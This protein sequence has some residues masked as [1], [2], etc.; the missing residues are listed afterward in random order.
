M[1]R[2]IIV[3][4]K[5]KVTH[6]RPNGT[7]RDAYIHSINGG[8]LSKDQLHFLRQKKSSR[9]NKFIFSKRSDNRHPTSLKSAYANHFKHYTS[10]G[11][12]RD[13]YVTC[14]EG[15]N[16]QP[17]RW[18]DQPDLKFK[19]SLRVQDNHHYVCLMRYSEGCWEKQ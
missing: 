7:G 13:H 19:N 5:G 17:Y 15:G 3:P 1:E 14:N 4:Q 18:T 8:F 12:G 9:G 11:T 6:Y 16:I 2:G 10:D